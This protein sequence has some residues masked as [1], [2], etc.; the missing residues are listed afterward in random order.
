MVSRQRSTSIS[1]GFPVISVEDICVVSD[2]GDSRMDSSSFL[3]RHDMPSLA[4]QHMLARS[5]PSS[6]KPHVHADAGSGRAVRH[7]FVNDQRIEE[8]NV[9]GFIGAHSTR[10]N[11]SV[12]TARS[13]R[14]RSE[15][16]RISERP[17]CR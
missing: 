11:P 6:D 3:G 16:S 13:Q 5:L 14:S 1:A 12:G 8:K 17:G 15:E 2:S 7:G 9:A 4:V 10:R